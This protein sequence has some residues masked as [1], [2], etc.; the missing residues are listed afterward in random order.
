[1]KNLDEINRE[2]LQRLETGTYRNA[3]KPSIIGNGKKRLPQESTQTN[4][5][6]ETCSCGGAGWLIGNNGVQ[7]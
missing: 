7:F 1:M 2:I 6:K 4:P 3:P 5:T